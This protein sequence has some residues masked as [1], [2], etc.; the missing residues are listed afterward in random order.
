MLVQIKQR[1]INTERLVGLWKTKF[2][3]KHNIFYECMI[4]GKKHEDF[5]SFDSEEEAE[6]AYWGLCN[7]LELHTVHTPDKEMIAKEKEAE[8]VKQA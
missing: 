5:V 2:Y 1:V 7:S 3:T 4:D 8:T 6:R